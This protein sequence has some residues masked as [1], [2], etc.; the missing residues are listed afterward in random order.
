[1]VFECILVLCFLISLGS[2]QCI[3]SYLSEKE[4]ES[5]SVYA[6]IGN[7]VKGNVTWSS[8]PGSGL[9]HQIWAETLMESTVSKNGGS[10]PTDEMYV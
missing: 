7:E 6:H 2:R 1:M 8:A 9:S 4:G 3:T 5:T 10:L